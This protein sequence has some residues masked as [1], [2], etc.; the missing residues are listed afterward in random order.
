MTKFFALIEG[1]GRFLIF[2]AFRGEL[3]T[4]VP[5]FQHGE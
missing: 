1:H 2:G 5:G 4:H 3:L